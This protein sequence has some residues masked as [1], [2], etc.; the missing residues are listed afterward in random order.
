M[1]LVCVFVHVVC[2]CVWLKI[3]NTIDGKKADFAEGTI[4][5]TKRY[6]CFTRKSPSPRK[7]L[8]ISFSLGGGGGGLLI[9]LPDP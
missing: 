9:M 8:Y 2:V 7:V 3:E 4:L 6:L 5:V 1:L